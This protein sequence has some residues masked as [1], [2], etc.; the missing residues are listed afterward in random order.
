M[1]CFFTACSG[2]KIN[3]VSTN[4]SAIYAILSVLAFSVHSLA[5]ERCLFLHFNGFLPGRNYNE[6]ALQIIEFVGL[7]L[8]L[9]PFVSGS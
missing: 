3:E 7:V 1:F 9:S 8:L 2:E 4:R 6:K 5:T